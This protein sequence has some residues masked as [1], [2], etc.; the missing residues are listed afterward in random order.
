MV[1]F[2][3]PPQAASAVED[4]RAFV[5]EIVLGAEEECGFEASDAIP[6]DVLD[7]V[8]TEARKR[9]LW[10]PHLP[11]AYG[12]QGLSEIALAHVHEE[13]GRSPLGPLA[14]NA[15]APDE[16]NMHALHAFG[17]DR[18]KERFLEPLAAGEARSCFAMTEPDAGADP[19][20]TSTTARKDGDEWVIDG[21][22]WFVTGAE[23]ADFAVIVAV[24]DPDVHPKQGTSLFIADTNQDGFVVE[25]D[26]PAMGAWS[27]G[28]HGELTLDG[29]RVPEENVLGPL[30][31]G[32]MVAQD[33]LALGRTTHA[34]RWIGMAQRAIDRM[35]EH[36]LER[37]SF[38]EKLASHQAV[39]WMIADSAKELYLARTFVLR[40]AAKIADSEDAS[41]EVSVLKHFAA[42][43]VQEIVD[44]AIQVH[45]SLGYSRDLLLERFFRDA[46]AGR[47]YDGPDE[48]HQWSIAQNV[49]EAME[50]E[51]TTRSATGGYQP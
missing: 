41:H 20:R 8:R 48:V 4:Y 30:G 36:A 3:L 38:G 46:R 47:I 22:K 12:G 25:R 33:R 23:G 32:Y 31:K 21:E 18:Q 7:R 28:G 16:G 27:I 42:N 1:N 15:M 17:T 37:E 6:T 9:E 50:E 34:M 19:Y 11:E 40:T 51:G 26:I 13:L 45:G 24:D 43:R 49:L 44:R 29:V 10:A 35:A 39:Q 5:D 2:E 14:V